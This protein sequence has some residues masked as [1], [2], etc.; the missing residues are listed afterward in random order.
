MVRLTTYVPVSVGVNASAELVPLV[1]ADPSR[2][3]AQAYVN[4]SSDPGSVA[5]AV[6][7]SADP[8][9]ELAGAPTIDAVGATFVPVIVLLDVPTPPSLSVTLSDSTY[10]PSSFGVKLNVDAAPVLY[11]TP[12]FVT[13]QAYVNVSATPGSVTDDVKLIAV[14]SGPVFPAGPPRI[15]ITGATLLTVTLAVATEDVSPVAES[16]TF[17]LTV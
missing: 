13:D 17:R 6:R 3:T 15:E 8:F 4:V 14:P 1:Y 16:V 5:D 10:V 2:V 9:G 12:F 11:K 7:F